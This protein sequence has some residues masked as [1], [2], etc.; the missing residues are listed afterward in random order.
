MTYSTKHDDV[1]SDNENDQNE[2]VPCD[3]VDEL[4]YENYL[5]AIDT[6]EDGDDLYCHFRTDGA[7][8]DLDDN[9]KLVDLR[10]CSLRVRKIKMFFNHDEAL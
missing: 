9:R 1:A 8:Q 4:S 3:R 6:D 2:M 5:I 7:P 10:A